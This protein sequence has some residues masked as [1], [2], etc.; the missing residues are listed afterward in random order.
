MRSSGVNGSNAAI[1]ALAGRCALY[2]HPAARLQTDLEGA[3]L[4]P[5]SRDHRAMLRPQVAEEPADG[6]PVGGDRPGRSFE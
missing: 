2:S 3:E 5:H 4:R 6:G 1:T